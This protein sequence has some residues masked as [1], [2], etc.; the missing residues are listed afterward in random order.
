MNEK[1][2]VAKSETVNEIAAPDPMQLLQTAV[3]NNFDIDKLKQL[4]DLQE[5]W[6]K[7]EAKKR[8]LAALSRFQTIVPNL[9]KSKVAKVTMKTGGQFQYTYADL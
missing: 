3:Q 9:K 2:Q 6:E 4:M 8:F 7:K 5:R 1:K